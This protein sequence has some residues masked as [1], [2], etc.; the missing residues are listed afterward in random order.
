[1]MIGTVVERVIVPNRGDGTPDPFEYC[2]AVEK[3]KQV[4]EMITEATG[5]MYDLIM[6]LRPS[7]LDELG[8][9]AVLRAQA[10]RYLAEARLHSRWTAEGLLAAG[11]TS[12]LRSIEYS[13]S[14]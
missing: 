14:N 4:Q 9:A 12:R 10:G 11:R 8:L 7:M 13:R 6:A 3:L 5:R 1:M 2:C